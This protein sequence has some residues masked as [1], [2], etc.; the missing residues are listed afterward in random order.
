MRLEKYITEKYHTT[1]NINGKPLIVFV[2]PSSKDMRNI[3]SDVIRFIAVNN[4]KKVYVCDGFLLIHI[5]IWRLLEFKGSP[6]GDKNIC[7]GSL[8]KKESKWR[9]T[10]SD[11]EKRYWKEK[12]E[13]Y[14]DFKWLE[15]YFNI[16]DWYLGKGNQNEIY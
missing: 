13:R 6:Y 7:M 3:K 12:E 11:S 1:L 9:M 4:S 5:E 2:N 8:V 14:E 15:K 16:S 10:Y